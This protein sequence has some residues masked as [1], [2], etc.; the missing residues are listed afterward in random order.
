[1]KFL[2]QLNMLKVAIILSFRSFA[3]LLLLSLFF[4]ACKQEEQ[5]D[6]L[7][8]GGR[9]A[10][11]EELSAGASTIFTSTSKAYDTPSDWVTGDLMERFLEGDALYDDPRVS[12]ES[13][14]SGG[15]GPVYAGYSCASCH[16]DAGRTRSTLFSAGGSGPYGF[17][18]FLTFIRTPHDQPFRQYG[19]VLHDQ[20]I[21]GSKPEGKLRATYTEKQYSFPDGETY[22]L[23]FPHYEIY[24]WY[25]DSIPVNQIEMSVRVPLRHV[26]MG[27]MMAVNQNEILRLASIQYPEYGISGKVNWVTERNKKYLGLSGHKAQ[28]ADLTIELGFSSDLG[29]TN[30][31]FPHE[32]AEGQSQVNGNYNIQVT[33]REMAAVDFYLHALGVPARRA[34]NNP[35]VQ[36]GGEL[37][38]QAKCNLCHTPTLHTQPGGVSLIDGTRVP[39]LGSQV[40][41]PYSDYLLHDMGPELGDDYSQFNASGDE[42]R[43]TPLWGAGLQEVVNGHS[44]FL[45]DGRARNFTEAIM[46]HGGE[47][48]VSR[49][50]FSKMT[51]E[52]R[53]TLIMFLR[54]L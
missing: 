25:A 32:I 54:S 46:W 3:L 51:K 33:T 34:V 18:S 9:V 39:W 16:N 7:T 17:S 8:P 11:P 27:P 1:M 4:Q 36:K 42:W 20:A 47:G 53:E 28:H 13:P 23:I 49:R 5:V 14:S 10:L 6:I 44:N 22:S 38:Y 35:V 52:E 21:Y 37:F 41:H 50:K 30:D 15:L 40:I 2:V 12:G 29:V 43:T 45:H 19:R 26:G 48:D 31:R 24:D